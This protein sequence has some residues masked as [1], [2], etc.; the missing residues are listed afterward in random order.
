MTSHNLRE[1]LAQALRL[2]KGPKEMKLSKKAPAKQHYYL[3]HE[4]WDDDYEEV[5]GYSFENFEEQLD[6]ILATLLAALPSPYLAET[7]E[8]NGYDEAIYDIKSL[9]TEAKTTAKEG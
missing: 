9:L 5:V 4:L 8:L 2:E 1:E 6:A 3:R 7:E